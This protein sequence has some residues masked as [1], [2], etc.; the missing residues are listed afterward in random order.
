MVALVIVV[1]LFA[2]VWDRY[3]SQHHSKNVLFYR[4]GI[5]DHDEERNAN[6]WRMATLSALRRK[7]HHVDDVIDYLKM[8]VEGAEWAVLQRWIQDGDLSRVKQLAVEVHLEEPDSI[9]WKYSI[10]RQLESSGFVRFFSRPNPWSA[11]VYLDQFNVSNPS[12]YE[13]AWY[14]SKFLTSNTANQL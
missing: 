1:G 2:G 9:P 8:D 5:S 11:G 12:C 6:G 14:N 3:R 7:L 13:L 4:I 10:I